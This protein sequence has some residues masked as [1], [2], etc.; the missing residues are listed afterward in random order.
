MSMHEQ[1]LRPKSKVYSGLIFAFPEFGYVC[2]YP[3]PLP[4]CRLLPSKKKQ[5]STYWPGLAGVRRGCLFPPSIPEQQWSLHI[6]KAVPSESSCSPVVRTDVTYLPFTKMLRNELVAI[7]QL[8]RTLQCCQAFMLEPHVLRK[9]TW[10]LL[11]CA[12]CNAGHSTDRFDARMVQVCNGE[13]GPR[14]LASLSSLLVRLVYGVH[15][16]EPR[17]RYYD[18]AQ[19]KDTSCVAPPA[20]AL[21]RSERQDMFFCSDPCDQVELLQLAHSRAQQQGASGEAARIHA[22]ALQCMILRG[23]SS[24]AEPRAPSTCTKHSTP[25]GQAKTNP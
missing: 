1:V 2:M 16:N 14:C 13:P 23:G 5:A 24:W 3:I 9:P 6:M 8:G 17:D 10:A 25:A 4:P 18:G 11:L 20:A 12:Q 21:L 7:W 15:G 19:P 22:H